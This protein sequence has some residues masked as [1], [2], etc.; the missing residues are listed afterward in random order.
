MVSTSRRRGSIQSLLPFA[1]AASLLSVFWGLHPRPRGDLGRTEKAPV[2]TA[3][4][5]VLD[6]AKARLELFKGDALLGV[7]ATALDAKNLHRLPPGRFSIHHQRAS[8]DHRREYLLA[9]PSL[10]LARYAQQQ[11][12][13]EPGA[14]ARV[15]EAHR[16]GLLPPQDTRLGPAI[17]LVGGG[18]DRPKAGVIHL[19][20]EDL[21]QLAPFLSAGVAVFIR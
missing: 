3:A 4:C 20:D 10:E 12:W 19:D 18:L 14:L 17:R 15:E 8:E 1:I 2:A 16:Y 21:E 6:R 11:G 7:F 5:L 13:L 9:Y